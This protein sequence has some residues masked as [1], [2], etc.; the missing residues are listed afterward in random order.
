M[1]RIHRQSFLSGLA[2]MVAITAAGTV[3]AQGTQN[4]VSNGSFETA[5][6]LGSSASFNGQGGYVPSAAAD[7]NIANNYGGLTVTELVSTSALPVA[8]PF[9]GGQ[10]AMHIHTFGGGPDYGEGSGIYQYLPNADNYSAW[11]F[12]VSG[13]ATLFDVQDGVYSTRT[14]ST[15]GQWVMLSGSVTPGTQYQE[16][17]IE[18]GD[19]NG[20]GGPAEFYVDFV[21]STI[22]VAAVPEPG[23]FALLLAGGVTG[24]GLLLRRRRK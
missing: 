15:P 1:K 6:P 23:A 16:I 5:G 12:V 4:A 7:W 24:V 20:N 8:E 13:Q 3:R 22:P 19:Q 11:F 17:A 21:Q 14:D 10:W 2:L 18:T 9:A